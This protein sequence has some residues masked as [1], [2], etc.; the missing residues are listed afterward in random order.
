MYPWDDCIIIEENGKL[1]ALPILK[2][3]EEKPKEE[4]T[5]NEYYAGSRKLRLR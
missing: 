3:K 2:S 1:M 5:D 4:K